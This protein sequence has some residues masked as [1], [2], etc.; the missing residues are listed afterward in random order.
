MILQSNIS[1]DVIPLL[2]RVVDV[3]EPCERTGEMGGPV[4]EALI[5]YLGSAGRFDEALATFNMM[6]GPT[7]VRCL[8][9]I[10]F[11]C[12]AAVPPRW[13][14][15]IEILH[16]SD[17]TEPGCGTGRIDQRALS[18]VVIACCRANQWEEAMNVLDLY[19]RPVEGAQG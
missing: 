2:S 16:A 13:E 8:R 19:G 7:G 18:H 11:Q 10:L 1:E 12:R 3:M 9:S 4:F 6:E 14:D 15:A 5:K 17:I